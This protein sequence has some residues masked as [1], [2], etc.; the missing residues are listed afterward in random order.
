V[1]SQQ[2]PESPR[3]DT[4]LAST[5]ESRPVAAWLAQLARTLKTCRLYDPANPAVVRFREELH[6]GLRALFERLD[7]MSLEIASREISYSGALVYRAASREDNVAAAFH[8]DGIRR[9]TFFKSVTAAELETF[10]DLVLHVTSRAAGEEDLV[11]LLWERELPSIQI[12]AAPQEGDVDGGGD[13]GPAAP[14]PLPWP[15]AS[16]AARDASGPGTVPGPVAGAGKEQAERSD[17]FE[18]PR[19]ATSPEEAYAELERT[20]PAEMARL[21]REYAAESEIAVVTRTLDALE[22]CL[23]S[24]TTPEDLRELTAFVPRVLREALTAGDW[25]AAS[26]ALG[27]LRRCDPE[28]V[29][30]SFFD[31]LASEPSAGQMRR[32][33]ATLDAQG[34]AGVEAFL[35]FASEAGPE[36]VE[37]LMRVLAESQDQRTRRPLARVIATLVGDRPERL[38]RWL[39]DER[40]YVV[41]NVVHILGWIGGDRIAVHLQAAVHH[42]DAR[43]R[44]EVVATLGT[45]SPELSRPVLLSMLAT[46]QGR[47]F[48]LIVQQLSLASVPAVGERLIELLCEERFLERAEDERRAVYRGLA[49]QGESV[50]PALVLELDRGGLFARGLDE[51]RREVARCIGRIGT[52]AA[53][54]A[55]E[56][57]ARSF[58]PGTRK[59]CEQALGALG[60]TDD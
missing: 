18:V 52:P 13:E 7:E 29:A 58:K 32:L 2:S 31:A 36:S 48:T 17:D 38:Q 46:A 55:L 3:A 9:I 1:A 6:Q 11:T 53:R 42:P 5:A 47:L 35:G 59:A 40:W 44:R 60:S 49:S 28:W 21:Q 41:R 20:A 43:V 51:H 54:G 39:Q 23:A 19:R 8:R 14:S 24:E 4:E 16:A 15:A 30:T 37:W 45:A 34:T 33:V 27:L 22:D 10:L 25:S 57:G 26:S 56:R 12:A 50:L